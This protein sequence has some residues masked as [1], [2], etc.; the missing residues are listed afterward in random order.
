MP[1]K[2]EMHKKSKAIA[3]GVT[4]LIVLVFVLLALFPS[5]Q[6]PLTITDDQID[7]YANIL[8]QWGNAHHKQVFINQWALFEVSAP[9]NETPRLYRDYIHTKEFDSR[10]RDIF[11]QSTCTQSIHIYFSNLQGALDS[12]TPESIRKELGCLGTIQFAQ[13]K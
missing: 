1:Q 6:E 2:L 13:L 5:S 3:I 4:L 10:L 8:M 9:V 7:H 12:T 11:E